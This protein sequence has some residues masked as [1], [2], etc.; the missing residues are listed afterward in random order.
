MGRDRYRILDGAPPGLQMWPPRCTGAEGWGACRS[1]WLPGLATPERRD[2]LPR[3]SVGARSPLEHGSQ[4]G[5]QVIVALAV[6]L[7]KQSGG[8]RKRLQRSTA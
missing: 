3:W 7:G 1:G 5:F 8:W 4:N 2:L 6:D